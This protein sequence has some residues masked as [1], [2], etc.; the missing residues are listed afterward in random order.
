MRSVQERNERDAAA[1]RRAHATDANGRAVVFEFP[2]CSPTLGLCVVQRPLPLCSS[3][4]L[5]PAASCVLP[6]GFRLPP[7]VFVSV[8]VHLTVMVSLIRIAA[9]LHRL[10]SVLVQCL[11]LWNVIRAS[12]ALV[13]A[14]HGIHHEP[15]RAAASV[16][17]YHDTL[18]HIL[19]VS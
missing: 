19:L 3:M 11:S 6:P 8:D 17:R 7:P 5:I 1:I 18:R 13:H 15:V 9:S 10:I 2:V 4:R 12:C 14:Y 16:G